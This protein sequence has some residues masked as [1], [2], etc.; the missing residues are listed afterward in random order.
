MML[1]G[2]VKL[3]ND[4]TDPSS[5]LPRKRGKKF[6]P[7]CS[8]NCENDQ[9]CCN[10]RC[11]YVIKPNIDVLYCPRLIARKEIQIFHYNFLCLTIQLRLKLNKIVIEVEYSYTL[12]LIF[13][14][15]IA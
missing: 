14:S 6:C 13:M 15:V 5:S 1:S 12:L 7:K 10:S 11:L 4:P 8:I 3:F 9:I 2:V